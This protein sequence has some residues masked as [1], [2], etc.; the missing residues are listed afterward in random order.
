[1]DGAAYAEG[2][3]VVCCGLGD[4]VLQLSLK[5][6]GLL[7]QVLCLIPGSLSGLVCRL[8]LSN[9]LSQ[10]GNQLVLVTNLLEV[11]Q[12]T[13]AQHSTAQ[14]STAQHSTAQHSTAQHTDDALM[15]PKTTL[16]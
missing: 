8:G 3:V 14:H 13:A 6:P 11:A 2:T 5:L 7:A 15:R 16:A 10:A 1:M 12:P 9:L 4:F